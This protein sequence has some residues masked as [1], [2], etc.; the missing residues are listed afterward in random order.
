MVQNPS[1]TWRRRCQTGMRIQRRGAEINAT[2]QPV[3]EWSGQPESVILTRRRGDAEISAEK[4]KD[5]C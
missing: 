4:A 1:L 5:N 3:V 2:D